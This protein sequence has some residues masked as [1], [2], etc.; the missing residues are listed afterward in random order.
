MDELGD[1]VGEPSRPYVV[2]GQDRVAIPEPGARVD[3]FLG[4]AL[5]LRVVPL[6]GREVELLS[7]VVSIAPGDAAARR[8]DGGGGTATEPDQHGRPTQHRNQ[9]P[10]PQ[11]RLR[12]VPG[13]DPAHSPR[14]HDGLVVAVPF[15]LRAFPSLLERAEVATEGRST[16]LVAEAGRPDRGLDHDVERCRDV[17]RSAGSFRLPRLLEARDAQGGDAEPDETGAALRTASGRRL[18]PD[19][20]SRARRRARKRGYR[21]GMVV[22]LHLHEKP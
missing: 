5:H 12:D 11:G 6:Y 8:G 3:D 21:G 14:D 22:G 2:Y 15:V 17:R 10:G 13:P 19:L 4:A 16:E 20:A 18:V 7:M 1:R 9:G